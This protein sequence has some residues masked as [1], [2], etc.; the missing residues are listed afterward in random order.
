MTSST[1]DI[2]S[3]NMIYALHPVSRLFYT[4]P[5]IS[6]EYIFWF[7]VMKH[8]YEENYFKFFYLSGKE[9]LLILP[10]P[11]GST[12]PGFMKHTNT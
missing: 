2:R 4:L 10:S 11:L 7:E 1:F 5:N 12:L 9:I 6:Q 8:I 3:A